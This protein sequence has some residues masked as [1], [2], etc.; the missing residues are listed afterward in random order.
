MPKCQYSHDDFFR[1]IGS[2]IIKRIEVM[3]AEQKEAGHSMFEVQSYYRK[4]P[5]L[6]NE[7]LQDDIKLMLQKNGYR[8]FFEET[9]YDGHLMTI[10]W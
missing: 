5:G 8:V 3:I 1:D 4:F 7:K 9:L 2:A 10:R 6:D